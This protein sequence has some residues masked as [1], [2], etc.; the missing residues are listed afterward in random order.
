MRWFDKGLDEQTKKEEM[1]S[2]SSKSWRKPWPRLTID[3][4]HPK[5]RLIFFFS[6]VGLVTVGLA[7]LVGGY[8]AYHYTESAEFCGTACHPMKSAFVRYQRSA[9]ANVD[10]AKCHIGEGASFF[11][12]SKV[13]GIAQVF[14]VLGDTYPRPIKGPVYNLRPARETCE[15]CHTPT[16]FRDNIIKTIV[17]YDNDEINTPVQATLILKMGGWQESTG[18][19]EG[20]HWHITNPVYYITADE[21]R[22]VV[23][24]VGTEQEDGSLKEFFARDML[25]MSWTSFVE[26]ARAEGKVRLMDCIDCHNRTAHFIPSPEVTVD[27]AINAGLISTDL[28]YVRAKAVEVMLPKYTSETAAYEAIAGLKDFYR[29]GYPEE[30]ASINPSFTLDDSQSELDTTPDHQSELDTALAELKK[31]YTTTTFPDM[32]LNWQ[33]NP[34]NERHSPFPGCFRCHDGKHVSVDPVGNE[35]EVISVKCNLCHTVPIVGRGTDRLIEAPVI[36]GDVPASHSDFRWTIEHRSVTDVE[37][38]ECYDCHGRGFCN[39]G[40]C[41]N[42]SHPPDMLFTHADEYRKQGDQVCY[43]CHQDILCSRCHPGGIVANP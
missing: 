38:Q 23:L 16:S 17:H 11:V 9:H 21:Q 18:M 41:H 2:T 12:K 7:I 36:V 13:T 24:W 37:D 29:V 22:Q 15:E 25:N 42:L 28:P 31:L 35:V 1:P 30:Q 10:C 32:G 26:E 6:C 34:N 19:S 39:N 4:N 40:A 3:L 5:H 8:T 43:T 20:I 27:G 33:T 14:A